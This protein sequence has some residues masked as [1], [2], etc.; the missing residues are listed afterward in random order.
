MELCSY[1]FRKAKKPHSCD[2]CGFE[3]VPGSE[4]ISI[5]SMQDGKFWHNKEHIHCDAILNAFTKQTCCE[6]EWGKYDSV[7]EWIHDEACSEC[8]CVNDCKKD[9]MEIMNCTKVLRTVLSPTILPSAIESVKRN[10]RI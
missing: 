3:I 5:R 6:I 7:L 2:V 10:I 4:Y 1:T 8:P 9:G